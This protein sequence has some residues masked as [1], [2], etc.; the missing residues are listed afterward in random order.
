MRTH[1]ILPE[2]LVKS[3][4]ALAGKGKRSQFIEE[5]IREKLRIDNLL[6]ALEATAGAF[7]ASDHPHWDTPEKVAA[8]VRES[9]RQDD[10]RID[11]YRLG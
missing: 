10:K 2:D 7:S 9:R 5:A 1:V 8:W 4:G 6:A 11:R 3:V